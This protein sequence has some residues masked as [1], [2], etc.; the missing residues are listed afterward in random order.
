MPPERRAVVQARQAVMRQ[1]DLALC[2]AATEHKSRES[3]KEKVHAAARIAVSR[4]ASGL[5]V[6]SFVS[7]LVDVCDDPM[8]I[9]ENLLFV[10]DSIMRHAEKEDGSVVKKFEKAFAPHLFTLFGACVQSSTN[11]VEV[12]T[13]LLKKLAAGPE[14]PSV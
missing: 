2:R 9:K 7:R 3:L 10:I 1:Y 5:E 12:A 8:A 11:R 6:K 13:Y 14:M 4:H